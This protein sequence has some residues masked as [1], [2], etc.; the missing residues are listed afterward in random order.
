MMECH[1]TGEWGLLGTHLLEQDCIRERESGD[2]NPFAG[3]ELLSSRKSAS[4][5]HWEEVCR[6]WPSYVAIR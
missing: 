3:G 5:L 4:I 6:H 2:S 1:W